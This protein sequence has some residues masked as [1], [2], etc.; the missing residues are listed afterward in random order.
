MGDLNKIFTEDTIS[1][2]TFFYPC[3]GMDIQSIIGLLDYNEENYLRVDNFV[4]V[5]LNMDYDMEI[6]D[7]RMSGIYDLQREFFFENKISHNQIEIIEKEQY[8][9]KEIE[10]FVGSLLDD[11]K[12]NWQ[13][14]NL[15]GRVIEPKAIRYKLRYKAYEFILYLIHY[16]ATIISERLRLT[17]D[18]YG[19]ILKHHVNG[20]Y[21]GD[22]FMR[23]M[24]EFSPF[25]L[26]KHQITNCFFTDYELVFSDINLYGKNSE[27]VVKLLKVRSALKLM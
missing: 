23:K 8:G 2:T 22:F 1:K 20:T 18:N 4:L 25:C 14:N 12:S 17:S 27:M 26:I 6:N 3:S 21:L 16:E 10:N 11:Y 15:V 9:L 7:L 13:F 24:E 5:D 19:L